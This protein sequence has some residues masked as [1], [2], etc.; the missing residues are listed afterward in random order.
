VASNA[1]GNKAHSTATNP[2]FW[3]PTLPS[4]RVAWRGFMR[5]AKLLA[6]EGRFDGLAQAVPVAEIN[7][8]FA[9]DRKKRTF[10]APTD[11]VAHIPAGTL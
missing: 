4:P 6:E 7:A 11:M 1:K 3:I 5:T 10:S 2:L 8:F 9:A